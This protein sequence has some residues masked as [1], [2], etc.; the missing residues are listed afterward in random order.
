MNAFLNTWEAPAFRREIGMPEHVLCYS[1]IRLYKLSTT[2]PWGHLFEIHSR[3][4][5]HVGKCRF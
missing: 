2:D 3:R 5:L 1:Y 4:S